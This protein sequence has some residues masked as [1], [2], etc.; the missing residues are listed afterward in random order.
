MGIDDA[1]GLDEMLELIAGKGKSGGGAWG[2]QGGGSV[3]G[4]E[5]EGG[6]GEQGAAS[7]PSSAGRQGERSESL[8][9]TWPSA[10]GALPLRPRVQVGGIIRPSQL[11]IG[12]E[13]EEVEE[14]EEE[15][16]EEEVVEEED[17][18]GEE[19][20]DDG[21]VQLGVGAASASAPAPALQPQAAPPFPALQQQ[22][23]QEGS[24]QESGG[25]EG[26]EDDLPG[27]GS[28]SRGSGGGGAGAG[29]PAPRLFALPLQAAGRVRLTAFEAEE[30]PGRAALG[31]AALAQLMG[32]AEGEGE[33]DI[34]MG[35]GRLFNK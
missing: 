20:V 34:F 23:Q 16:E 8:K 17:V 27:G 6:E 30:E 9:R 2:R 1:E 33:E 35:A 11:G 19:E 21:D 22:Q 3:V 32:A 4:E 7:P 18:M 13:E 14:E 29:A 25:R 28:S 12:E 26:M 31:A 15:V 5:E 10:F 24:W